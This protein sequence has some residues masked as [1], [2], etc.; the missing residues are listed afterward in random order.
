MRIETDAGVKVVSLDIRGGRVGT[1]TVDMGAP[2]LDGP[3]IP[4]AAEGR[5]ADMPF[6]VD[7][8]D[9]EITCVSMGNPHCVVFLEDVAPLDLARL[10]PPFE[11][12]P[13]FPKRVNTE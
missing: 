1:G 6:A 5:V 13:F 2:I 12:H 7:G 11:H 4:V 10:G 8:A 9:Y 3:A